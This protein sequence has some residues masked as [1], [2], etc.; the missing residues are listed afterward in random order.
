MRNQPERSFVN[1]EIHLTDVQGR[2]EE[3][4]SPTKVATQDGSRIDANLY[5]AE[6]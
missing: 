1:E 2:E 3:A 5:H 4:V 6:V